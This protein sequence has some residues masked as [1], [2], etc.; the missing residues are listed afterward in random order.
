MAA[1]AGGGGGAAA[2]AAPT[3][4][5][6]AGPLMSSLLYEQWAADNDMVRGTRDW[7]RHWPPPSVH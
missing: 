2:A 1:T 6:V 5:V 4:A 7:P 3:A